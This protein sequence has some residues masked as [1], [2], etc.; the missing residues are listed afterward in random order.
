MIAPDSM[1]RTKSPP[2]RRRLP[3]VLAF[4]T[5]AATTLMLKSPAEGWRAIA[6]NFVYGFAYSACIGCLGWLILPR[7]GRYSARIQPVVGWTIVVIA[8]IAI[9]IVGSLI[10]LVLMSAVG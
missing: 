9:A 4:A 2:R 6:V 10:A 7:V 1:Q 5:A 8:T 3:Y